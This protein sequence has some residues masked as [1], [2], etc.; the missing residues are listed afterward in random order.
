VI[1]EEPLD[2]LIAKYQSP[3]LK[4]DFLTFELFFYDA[5]STR[6]AHQLSEN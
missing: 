1:R 6:W 2:Q 5:L 3:D 4:G